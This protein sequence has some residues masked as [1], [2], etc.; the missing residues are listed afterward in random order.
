MS[1]LLLSSLP[2]TFS[3]NQGQPNVGGGKAEGRRM[4]EKEIRV[5]LVEVRTYCSRER[6]QLLPERSHAPIYARL[7]AFRGRALDMHRA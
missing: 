4:E 5:S 2:T 6:L 7:P 3:T 1:N